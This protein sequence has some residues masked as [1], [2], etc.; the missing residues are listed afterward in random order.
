MRM[1][2]IALNVLVLSL[3]MHSSLEFDR[4]LRRDDTFE[5]SLYPQS[6]IW[7]SSLG[8]L[9]SK[10][11]IT[12]RPFVPSP[13]HVSTTAEGCDVMFLDAVSYIPFLIA[14]LTDKY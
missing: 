12:C 13:N 5:I 11:H 2:Y 8:P 14:N 3:K 9:G 6:S 4:R 10:G 7:C 1:V